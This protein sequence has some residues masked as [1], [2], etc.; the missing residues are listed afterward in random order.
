[1]TGDAMDAARRVAMVTGA[2]GAIGRAI[3]RRIAA[4]GG[5]EVVLAARD[6]AAARDAARE[7]SRAAGGAN[8]RHELVDVS[9][10]AS[11][12]ALA[13]RWRGPLH[14]L[15]N[16]AATA[17]RRRL[18]TPEGIELQLATNVLGYLWMTLAFADTLRRS[19]PSRVV[20]VASY[21]A[22]DLDVDDLAFERRPYD[23]G[24]AYRQSKQADRMLTVA[25]ARRLSSD[26]ITVNACHPGDVDSKLSND[27]GF[28]GSASADEGAR[29]PAWLAVSDEVEG[30]TG[31]YFAHR[32]REPDRFADDEAAIER[33][34]EAC[35]AF[36]PRDA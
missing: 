9:R 4:E 29:T 18:E 23:N 32:R 3:A 8:V 11:I 13:A 6:E 35:M 14:V 33:L 36:T 12:Q 19:A 30:Q 26:G 1:M 10:W 5:F 16:N 22:G 31:R 27:L 28:G 7:I 2:T 17:P 21:W 20:N 34:Y 15:V 25:L 24:T